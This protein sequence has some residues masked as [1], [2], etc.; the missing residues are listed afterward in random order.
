M[1][2]GPKVEHFVCAPATFPVV[3]G[4]GGELRQGACTSS[5]EITNNSQ[6]ESVPVAAH[7]RTL[8]VKLPSRRA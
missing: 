4:L 2:N 7:C 6:G 3:S 8:G 1:C 5:L